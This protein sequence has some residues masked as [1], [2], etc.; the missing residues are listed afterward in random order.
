MPCWDAETNDPGK[1]REHQLSMALAAVCRPLVTV[2]NL[3]LR[4]FIALHSNSANA[5]VWDDF[6]GQVATATEGGCAVIRSKFQR[7]SKDARGRMAARRS[8]CPKCEPLLANCVQ[9]F[10]LIVFCFAIK[11]QPEYSEDSPH[12]LTVS[13]VIFL[14]SVLKGAVCGF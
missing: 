10:P 4:R 14:S 8:V 12:P 6:Y 3:G 5:P 7:A 13:I 1:A 2:N 11:R 9:F